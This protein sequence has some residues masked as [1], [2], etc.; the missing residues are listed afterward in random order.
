MTAGQH[1]T[2]MTTLSSL[3]FTMF[4]ELWVNCR[5]ISRMVSKL[6]VADLNLFRSTRWP[7]NCWRLYS[8]K[9]DI[10]VVCHSFCCNNASIN[11]QRT[12]SWHFT[13]SIFLFA[14]VAII[15]YS[16]VLTLCRQ[17]ANYLSSKL[18]QLLFKCQPNQSS[19]SKVHLRLLRAYHVLHIVLLRLLASTTDLK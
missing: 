10:Y 14:T 19:I 15:Q 16:L 13:A 4:S 1:Q 6:M 3:I 11:T 8:W 5:N 7:R 12:H 18:Q 9:Q 2:S 17:R